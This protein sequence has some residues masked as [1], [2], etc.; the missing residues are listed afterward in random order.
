MGHICT[1]GPC[2]ER[3]TAGIG[4]QIEEIEVLLL[5][6]SLLKL[7]VLL[8]V[9]AIFA[10]QF[11][12]LASEIAYLF[13]VDAIFFLNSNS[14]QIYFALTSHIQHTS[15]SVVILDCRLIQEVPQ[16]GVAKK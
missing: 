3:G 5:G 10:F 12:Q 6:Q 2:R 14:G 11:L 7:I 16:L 9:P 15:S 8:C 4:K 1:G 13:K